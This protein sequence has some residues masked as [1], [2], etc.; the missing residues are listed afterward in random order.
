MRRAPRIGPTAAVLLSLALPAR[1]GAPITIGES[2]TIA[3]KALGA[4]RTILV[5]TPPFYAGERQRYPV[6]Y[7]ADGGAH[8]VHTRGTVDL[9]ARQG[10]IPQ[11]VIVGI[12]ATDT[13]ADLAPMNVASWMEGGGTI[14]SPTGGG[15]DAFLN[16]VAGELV[17]YVDANF[18]TV[19]FRIFCGPS[20]AGLL[21]TYA[22]LTRPSLF[23]AVIA[24]SPP[25]SWGNDVI[26][27]LARAFFADRPELK[28]TYFV[29]HGADQPADRAA[30]E[31]LTRILKDGHLAGMR[32]GAMTLG[33]SGH[34]SMVPL[35]VYYGLRMIFEGW[36][37]PVDPATGAPSGT[38]ADVRTHYAE[39]SERLGYRVEP[40]EATVDRMGHAALQRHDRP[41]A[42]ELFR[43]NVATHPEAANVYDSLGEALEADGQL[44][45]AAENYRRAYEIAAASRNPST[46]IYRRHLERLTGRPEK[47]K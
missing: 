33:Q 47:P 18:R 12:P 11:L 1:A 45:L 22:M 2:F 31:D 15:G 16:F 46:L 32:W 36:A 41:H 43:F 24:A 39:L 25:L 23:N 30:L 13:A 14:G 6:L 7:L 44:N 20:F 9:L 42:L 19:P 38:L 40:D 17:P 5:S 27:K 34:P 35:S 29:T 37:L 26:V 4:E 10:L 21:G 3:S 28:A 8:I